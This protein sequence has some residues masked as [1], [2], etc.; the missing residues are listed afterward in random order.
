MG[1]SGG[2]SAGGPGYSGG[3]SGSGGFGGGS[4]AGGSAG[5][6]CYQLMFETTVASP[7]ALVLGSMN[8][9]E[10]CDLELLS[11]PTRIAVL[12]RPG[13]DLLGAIANRWE[14]LVSCIGQGV[15]FEAE[16]LSG[17]SPVRV[18]VTPVP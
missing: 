13:G 15:A 10:V 14:D 9:G 12:T 4:G 6:D 17:T 5:I 18:R 8:V 2:G 1:G 3:G 7:D 11:N 16:L